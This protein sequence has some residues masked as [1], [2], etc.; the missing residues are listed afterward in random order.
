[1]IRNPVIRRILWAFLFW[2]C[3]FF[4]W[5]GDFAII[6]AHKY[7]PANLAFFLLFIILAA[8]FA[9]LFVRSAFRD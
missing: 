7:D 5:A 2:V 6:P 9:F 8:L 1:M 4:L 3:I